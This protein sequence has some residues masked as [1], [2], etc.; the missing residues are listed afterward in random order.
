MKFIFVIIV[1][2]GTLISCSNSSDFEIAEI[3]AIKTF[4]EALIDR[5]ISTILL[6][7]RKI[8]TRKK[9]DDAKIPVLFV[10]LENGQNVEYWVVMD[11][12]KIMR[13]KN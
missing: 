12:T 4:E 13:V 10:E 3:E 2:F 5:N 1:A 8:I 9:I 11:R 7:T 6:D